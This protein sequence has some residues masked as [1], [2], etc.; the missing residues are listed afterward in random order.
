MQWLMARNERTLGTS[1]LTTYRWAGAAAYPVVGGYVAWRASKGKEDRCPP[2][3]A[4]RHRGPRAL[5]DR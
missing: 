3:G 4:L 1:A 5:L 2:P